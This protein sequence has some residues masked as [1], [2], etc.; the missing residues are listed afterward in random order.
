[1]EIQSLSLCVPAGCPNKCK[2]CVSQMHGDKYENS[3]NKPWGHQ[4]FIDRLEYARDNGTQ[5]L[6]L[7]GNGEP[8]LN[9]KFI[10]Q[11]GAFNKGLRN[12]FRHIEIQTSGVGLDKEKLLSLR[13]VGVKTISLSLSAPDSE[14]NQEYNQTP[15][16]VKVNIPELCGQIK[17]EGFN[18]RLSLNMTDA[19]N[20]M[21]PGEIFHWADAMGA[22]QVT[23]RVLY[24]SGTELP[25][26]KWVA[27]HRATDTLIE[28]INDYVMK[29]GTALN[30]LSF[31]A[32]KYDV[33]GISVVVD[34]DCMNTEV[35]NTLKYLI[36]REDC[37]LYTHWDKK[38][39]LVY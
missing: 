14:T 28:G 29:H 32:M 36:L 8:L 38:G 37:R 4:D 13:T 27:E 11:F 19:W 7:T 17:E 12:P 2:F 18:L 10:N 26:D 1:M 5:C 6:I 3:H 24:T 31:G 16:K 33:M 23:F 30:R 35:K 39:S 25:Q 9:M 22:N 20:K 34:T 15:K 21:T